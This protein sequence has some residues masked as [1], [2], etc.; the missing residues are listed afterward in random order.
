M[1]RELKCNA[2]GELTSVSP[3]RHF[4]LFGALYFTPP[5]YSVERFPFF[6]C[7]PVTISGARVTR[8]PGM[9]GS[10]YAGTHRHHP[11]SC[12]LSSAL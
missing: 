4:C 2:C 7:F 6:F 5:L 12:Y 10:G 1:E 11:P 9:D 3:I 8:G